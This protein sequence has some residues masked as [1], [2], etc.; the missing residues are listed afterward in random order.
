MLRGASGSGLLASSDTDVWLVALHGRSRHCLE[1]VGEPAA[2][3][4]L[5]VLTVIRDGLAGPPLS[6]ATRYVGALQPGTGDDVTVP[7]EVPLPLLPGSPTVAVV[8]RESMPVD[9]YWEAP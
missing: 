1:R 2:D 6:G 4:M 5:D 7:V 9:Q 3:S 8:G